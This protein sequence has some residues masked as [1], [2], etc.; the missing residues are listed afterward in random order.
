MKR[1][2]IQTFLPI[3]ISFFILVFPFYLRCSYFAEA[4][5][6]PTDLGFENPD[7]EGQF[8][9]Q[10]RDGLKAFLLTFSLSD[11]I[12]RAMCSGTLPISFLKH[13]PSIKK[14]WSFAID[15]TRLLRENDP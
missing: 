7:Q 5:L 4:N 14:T 12:R 10:Q 8:G 3:A 2:R 6:F 11:S 1:S 15:K 9:D 13:L